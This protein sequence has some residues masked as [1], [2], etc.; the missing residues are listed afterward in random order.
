MSYIGKEAGVWGLRRRVGGGPACAV[1]LRGP[2]LPCT[3]GP[4]APPCG[5][6]G[7]LIKSGP[8]PI[9]RLVHRASRAQ[10]VSRN[11][12][13]NAEFIFFNQSGLR[14]HIEFLTT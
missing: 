6:P 10:I 2:G 11:T 5:P 8:D 4:S 14:R 9:R 7:G 3:G 12:V 13:V 1:G